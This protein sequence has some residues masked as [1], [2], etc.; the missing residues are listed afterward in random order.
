MTPIDRYANHWAD[1]LVA[2][3]GYTSEEAIL[4][5]LTDCFLFEVV[6]RKDGLEQMMLA[7]HERFDRPAAK[8]RTGDP[9]F[10][11]T[12][13]D[14]N[15]TVILQLS[16]IVDVQPLDRGLSDAS[17]EEV[18]Q[19]L[20]DALD[21]DD[22]IPDAQLLAVEAFRTRDPETVFAS[23]SEPVF[24][25]LKRDES[26]TATLLFT[27]LIE[28][29][30]DDP[31]SFEPYIPELIGF[32][33]GS[34]HRSSAV[35]CL[36]TLAEDD[37]RRVLDAVPALATAAESGG[38][39]TRKW[40]IYALSQVAG[41]YPE[42]VFPTLDILVEAIGTDEIHLRLN[43]LSAIGNVTSSYPDTAVPLLEDIVSLLESDHAAIR[44]NTLGL[45]GDLAQEHAERVIEHVTAIA[46]LLTDDS[47]TVRRNAAIALVRAC[48]ADKS[49]VAAEHT[50]LE[51]A[52]EDQ[53]PAV[54][55]NACT[56]IGRVG[57]PV[58]TAKLRD[59]REND[60]DDQVRA[61]AAMA[62]DRLA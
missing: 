54:R 27:E 6:Y 21:S 37:P 42:A 8:P 30:A 20:D 36:A 55:A 23:L 45:L 19:S 10:R 46:G 11:F 25:L 50:Q 57:A 34:T 59:L 14:D 41:E 12:S 47:V 2:D 22:G 38:D 4:N 52:L 49:A 26:K 62:L 18:G 31:A 28:Y 60:P 17:L 39:E 33:T 1:R 44:G 53:N 15:R 58:S 24:S 32:A 56:V 35:Q 13:I 29:A 61:Q 5:A 51:A 16:E 3:G 43:A 48:D 9:V 40:A 7:T